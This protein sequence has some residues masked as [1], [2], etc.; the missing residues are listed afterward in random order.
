MYFLQLEN[1][2]EYYDIYSVRDKREDRITNCRGKYI[3]FI[4][5]KR[6]KEYEF[7][8][9][10]ITAEDIKQHIVRNY[11]DLLELNDYTPLY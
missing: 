2:C 8:Q 7:Y 5:W 10:D 6:S 1:N 3:D 9:F 4:V 11:L